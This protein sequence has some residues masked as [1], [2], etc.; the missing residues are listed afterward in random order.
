MI[1]KFLLLLDNAIFSD[2]I[3]KFLCDNY[4]TVT[5]IMVILFVIAVIIISKNPKK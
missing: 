3:D 4:W 5:T 2:R 1:N